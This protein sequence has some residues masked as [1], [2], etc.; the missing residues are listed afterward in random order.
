[1]NLTLHE[2]AEAFTASCDPSLVGI[3]ILDENLKVSWTN[4]QLRQILEVTPAEIMGR[5]MSEVFDMDTEKVSRVNM[6]LMEQGQIRFFPIRRKF[7][8]TQ[9]SLMIYVYRIPQD[10]QSQ[11][12][13]FLLNAIELEEFAEVEQELNLSQG[14]NRINQSIVGLISA[15]IAGTITYLWEHF[16]K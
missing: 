16:N 1:M 8:Q 4:S 10:G 14:P 6:D 7:V 15:I 5:T 13:K 11:L 3:A 12:Q 9:K 2:K